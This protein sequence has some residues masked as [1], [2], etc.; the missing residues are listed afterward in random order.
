MAEDDR[1][2]ADAAASKMVADEASVFERDVGV[3]DQGITPSDEGVAGDP[4]RQRAFVDPVVPRREAIALDTPVVVGIHTIIDLNR[5]NVMHVP[6][7]PVSLVDSRWI[8]HFGIGHL[9]GAGIGHLNGGHGDSHRSPVPQAARRH[10]RQ[11]WGE[12]VL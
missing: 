9:Q 2:G 3:I 6:S 11:E 7:L 8:D 1:P 10:A 12:T 5:A 4:Q